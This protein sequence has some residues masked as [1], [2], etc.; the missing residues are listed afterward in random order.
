MIDWT[1]ITKVILYVCVTM[2]VIFTVK[3][4]EVES[5]VIVECQKACSSLGNQLVEVTSRSC[6]CTGNTITS[7]S[8]SDNPWIM[9]RSR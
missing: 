4:C 3:S 6:E 5:S 7:A 8:N 2:V 9:P 1:A